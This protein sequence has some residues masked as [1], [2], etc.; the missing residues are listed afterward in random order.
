[1]RILQILV[2]IFFITSCGG[3]ST[4][5]QPATVP[6]VS[7]YPSNGTILST[8]CNGTTQIVITADGSGGN[9]V[10][11]IENSA[12]C[13]YTGNNIAQPNGQSL[14]LKSINISYDDVIAQTQSDRASKASKVIKANH[15]NAG[16]YPPVQSYAG[17]VTSKKYA[18]GE[19]LSLLPELVS[20]ATD[21]NGNE[22]ELAIACDFSEVDIKINKMYLLDVLS[23]EVL[24]I[25]EVPDTIQSDCSMTYQI[26]TFVVEESG[27]VY[28]IS[29]GATADIIDIAPANQQG[30]NQSDEALIIDSDHQIYA[31]E[32]T[33]DN[34]AELTQLTTPDAP[35]TAY[36]GFILAPGAFSYDGQYLLAASAAR[37]ASTAT[38]FLFEK[39][40]TRFR[41]LRPQDWSTNF[42]L[43]TLLDDEGNFLFHYAS[44]EFYILNTDNMEYSKFID[45]LG[46]ETQGPAEAP[47]YP[48]LCD[49]MAAWCNYTYSP[50]DIYGAV[51]RYNQW[52][53]GDRGAAW[54]YSTFE[55]TGFVLCLPGTNFTGSCSPAYT[56]LVDNYLY[57]VGEN[58]SKFVKYNL[59]TNF[60]ILIDLDEYGFLA[61]DYEI[62]RD[63]ALVEVINSANS[64]KVFLELNLNDGSV[65]ERGVI[66]TG[67][68][69][70]IQF[71]PLGS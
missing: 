69:K 50:S 68:R 6:A 58:L 29:N 12:E 57:V 24:I 66:K 2:I 5:S 53:I 18:S 59:N 8:S 55:Q 14:T 13:G 27:V 45:S 22:I 52:I 51:G 70:V 65:V 37:A 35:I 31:L 63:I 15:A 17:F 23:R 4:T 49:S 7:S 20:V 54:N 71:L 44:N 60:S 30:I 62:Y 47:I 26:A 41:I 1:M 61:R 39:G 43:S 19:L 64:D 40:S 9:T 34:V 28:E 38:F 46:I 56:N 11:N 25:A 32:I 16:I 3:G 67:S 33:N 36:Y 48:S 42:Y 10:S 21:D